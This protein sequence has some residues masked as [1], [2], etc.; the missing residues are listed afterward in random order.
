MLNKFIGP[1]EPMTLANFISLYNLNEKEFVC[2]DIIEN[3][4]PIEPLKKSYYRPDEDPYIRDEEGNLI[5]P[6]VIDWSNWDLVFSNNTQQGLSVDE[7]LSQYGTKD[8]VVCNCEEQDDNV[9]II[10]ITVK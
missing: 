3:T 2:S 8:V 6:I 7:V 4:E 9:K 10:T 5:Y 1:S